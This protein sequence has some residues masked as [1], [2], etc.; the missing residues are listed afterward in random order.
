MLIIMDT[1]NAQSS[2][3]CSDISDLNEA[4]G[5]WDAALCFF[6]SNQH[7]IHISLPSQSF[8]LFQMQYQDGH[9]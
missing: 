1:D 9:I 6:G 3:E 4:C 5:V 7:E 8:D 2:S